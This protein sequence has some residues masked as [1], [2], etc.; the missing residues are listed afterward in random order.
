[1]RTAA[2]HWQTG[3]PLALSLDA[4]VVTEVGPTA[5]RPDLPWVAPSFCDLQVNGGHG[6]GF[7]DPGLTAGGVKAV[8]DACRRHGCGLFLPTVITDSP[9]AVERAFRTL[10]AAVNADPVLSTMIP[11]F[12]LEG[13]FICP[14]D[15]YRGA[16]PVGH[17]R[18]PDLGL[19]E[20]WQDAAGGRIALVTLAPERPGALDLIGRLTAAGVAVALGHTAADAD[21]IAAAAAAGARLST[22]LGNG[23]PA[24][25]PRHANPVWPQLAD[26]RLWASVIADGHHLPA[27]VLACVARVKTTGRLV[28]VSDASPPAGLPPGGHRLWGRDVVLT[29]DGRVLLA[30]TPYLAG[31]GVFL[32]ACVVGAVRH[33]RLT[34]EAA[35]LAASVRP[36]ELLGLPVPSLAVG[37][38]A[39]LVL[40]DLTPDGSMAVRQVAG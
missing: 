30:G 24:V 14:D 15:G 35:V 17:V 40:F 19:F 31:S 8:A 33:G 23:L 34:V 16:H 28:L 18:D 5:D 12:H 32:D 11:G 25:L 21:A 29:A 13:P 38:P 20:R 2:R 7:N 39:D 22:H 1:M 4:G 37:E 6:V 10:A 9:E 27:S 26:D 3:R 36:R